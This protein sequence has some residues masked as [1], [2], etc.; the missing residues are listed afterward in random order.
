MRLEAELSFT[1]ESEREAESVVKAVSPDNI[2]VPAG[3]NVKM[4]M[5]NCHPQVSVRCEKSIET[6]L[7][8]LDDLLACISVA[9]RTFETIRAL[10][11]QSR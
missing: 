4:V 5:S 8:T 9:E 6:F 3:L 2:K 7:A 11:L 1:Y 10:R